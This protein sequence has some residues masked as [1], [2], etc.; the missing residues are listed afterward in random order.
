MSDERLTSA[1][2]C[3][4]AAG[5]WVDGTC[6]LGEGWQATAAMGLAAANDF[7]ARVGTYVPQFASDAMQ[8]CDVQL[9]VSVL[10]SGSTAMHA[11]EQLTTQVLDVDIAPDVR[12]A[13]RTCPLPF[14][15]FP[16]PLT[17][18]AGSRL[19]PHMQVVVGP[20]RSTVS[21]AAALLRDFFSDR[22]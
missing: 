22:R 21:E 1:E 9:S 10:D 14:A 7:N 4:G 13:N 12:R 8:S 6:W 18:A 5:R 19:L 15:S 3:S 20:L 2:L 17:S 11:L 16:L